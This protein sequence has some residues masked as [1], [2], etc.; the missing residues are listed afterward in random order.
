MF[1]ILDISAQ[2][3]DHDITG[4]APENTNDASSSMNLKHETDTHR[5]SDIK[6]WN[7]SAH[8][9][10]RHSLIAVLTM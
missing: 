9:H 2:P 7:S 5:I 3:V 10:V 8:S 1:D 4:S 6:A